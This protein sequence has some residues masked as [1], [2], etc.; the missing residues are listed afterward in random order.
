MDTVRT[1]Y[2]GH[3]SL[4]AIWGRAADRLHLLINDSLLSLVARFAIAGVFLMSGRTKV[5]GFLTITDSTY[6]LFRTEYKLPLVPPEIAAHMAAYAEHLFPVLLI[7][8]LF[9][10]LSA[11]AL[12]GMTTVIEVFVYP[13]AWATHLTWA[14]L[15]LIIIAKGA[16]KLSLDHRLGIK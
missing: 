12:L 13:D 4:R 8:G 15:L 11:F 2:A 7:L 14:G 9:S 10:R 1:D 5:E 16:G 6:E 3:K